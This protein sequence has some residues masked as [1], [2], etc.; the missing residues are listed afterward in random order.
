MKVDES[1]VGLASVSDFQAVEMM[2]EALWKLVDFEF[3][4][5]EPFVFSSNFPLLLNSR[6]CQTP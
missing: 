4:F 3:A 2:L 1:T 5:A 6:G